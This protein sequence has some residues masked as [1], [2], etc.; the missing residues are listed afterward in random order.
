[1]TLSQSIVQG[2]TKQVKIFHCHYEMSCLYIITFHMH[3]DNICSTCVV[4]GNSTSRA[5]VICV[6]NMDETT[7]YNSS[8]TDL[9]PKVEKCF[10]IKNI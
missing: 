9:N 2:D 4:L 1:M 6:V 5:L 10:I 3:F 8:L 7:S